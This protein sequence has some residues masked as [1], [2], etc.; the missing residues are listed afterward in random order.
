MWI[1]LREWPAADLKIKLFADGAEKAAMLDVQDR[2]IQDFT[3]NPLMRNAGIARLC[4]LG[5]DILNAIPD[6]G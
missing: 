4:V 1:S 5:R 6:L 2:L 3:P